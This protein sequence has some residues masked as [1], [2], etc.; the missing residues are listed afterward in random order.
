MKWSSQKTVLFEVAI[1]KM[2]SPKQE[3]SKQ[4]LED[5]YTRLNNI[6]EEIRS[7]V[8]IQKDQKQ[9]NEKVKSEPKIANIPKPK[10]EKVTDMQIEKLDFWPKIIQNLKEQRKMMLVSNLLNTVAT[11]LNDMTVGIVFQNG[12]TPFVKS[13]IEKPENFQELTKLISIEC[14]RQMTIKLL[15][16]QD[17]I[18][19]KKAKETHPE[20]KVIKE[21]DIPINII[22]E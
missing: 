1:I 8:K 5:I 12:L 7:G 15:D 20:E 6:E 19:K 13:I 9:Q 3:A 22:E 14:G 17:E 11:M 10:V 2:C 18:L 16:C 21:L 4:G